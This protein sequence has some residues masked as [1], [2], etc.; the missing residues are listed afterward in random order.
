MLERLEYILTHVDQ[1]ICQLICK[2]WENYSIQSTSI[3]KHQIMQ[4]KQQAVEETV[5]EAAVQQQEEETL[6]E[7]KRSKKELVVLMILKI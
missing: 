6:K 4:L 5:Q 7:E 1:K 3:K 2:N